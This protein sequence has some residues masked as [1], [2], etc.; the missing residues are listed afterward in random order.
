MDELLKQSGFYFGNALL[1]GMGLIFAIGA[2]A[3]AERKVAK[4]WWVVLW[5][6]LFAFYLWSVFLAS[7]NVVNALA[8]LP[9][10]IFNANSMAAV[11][12]LY[13]HFRDKQLLDQRKP[14]IICSVIFVLVLMSSLLSLFFNHPDSRY[15]PA[16]TAAIPS[17]VLS[18]VFFVLLAWNYRKQHMATT[19][20]LLA[21]ANLQLPAGIIGKQGWGN[22]FV[23]LLAAKLSL[24]GAMYHMLGVR[25]GIQASLK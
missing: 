20:L 2:P 23:L 8:S 25:D 7:I 22:D 4:I 12:M 3:I 19:L 18:W 17:Q 15:L 14:A 11:G 10:A 24:I 1:C 13:F 5:S 6:T 9:L 16:G 21:Y